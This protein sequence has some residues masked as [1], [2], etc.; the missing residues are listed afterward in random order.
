MWAWQEGRIGGL[1]ALKLLVYIQN[2]NVCPSRKS[3]EGGGTDVGMVG[4]KEG[5]RL[6]SSYKFYNSNTK[7]AFYLKEAQF[8]RFLTLRG[9]MWPLHEPTLQ[10]CD[11]NP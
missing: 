5:V 4:G 7:P 1:A 8:I 10:C 11:L 9:Q 3:A 2:H 6:S